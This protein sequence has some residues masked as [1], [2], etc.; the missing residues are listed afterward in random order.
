MLG[1]AMPEALAIT[2]AVD[3]A[4]EMSDAYRDLGRD[5]RQGV[6]RV[7]RDASPVPGDAAVVGEI[8]GIQPAIAGF[9]RVVESSSAELEPDEVAA[10]FIGL[11][12]LVAEVGCEEHSAAVFPL[13]LPDGELALA[14]QPLP[15]EAA[16]VGLM[17]RIMDRLELWAGQDDLGV[18]ERQASRYWFERF[19]L[20]KHTEESELSHSVREQE[21]T[22][23]GREF[24]S[25][26]D[27]V[28]RNYAVHEGATLQ[29]AVARM[30]EALV[31]SRASVFAVRERD[32]AS[33]VLEDLSDGSRYSVFEHNESM[34][35]R[36]DAVTFGRLLPRGD[37]TYARSAGMVFSEWPGADAGVGR[38]LIEGARLGLEPEVLLEG[39]LTR[40]Q[41]YTI[42]RKVR[43]A[44]S[45]REAN[46][47]LFDFSMA[48]RE[49][50]LARDLTPA[51]LP[52]GLRELGA[53]AGHQLLELKLDNVLAE[54]YRALSEQAGLPGPGVAPVGSKKKKR[55]KRRR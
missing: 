27:T 51:A 43:P 2:P 18:L 38:A 52:S 45:R 53:A 39:M 32:G 48:L 6:R 54:W 4:A 47:L 26:G 49:A 44:A 46:D 28:A 23:A 25:L 11:I 34:E 40:A 41:G 14:W 22:F 9:K 30:L 17:E 20:P 33:V 10:G 31:R 50:G 29:P 21:F 55:K 13:P 5:L 36:P 19:S 1:Q 35:Y 15:R 16:D 24:V 7:L 3:L 12:G 37:G 42:P 8:G